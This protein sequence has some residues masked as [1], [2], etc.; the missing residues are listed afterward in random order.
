MPTTQKDH[1]LR[2]TAHCS[3]SDQ[4]RAATELRSA[5]RAIAD[6]EEGAA[7]R[8]AEAPLKELGSESHVLT[9]QETVTL[10]M[11]VDRA[12][13]AVRR[14]GAYDI[15]R[16]REV[17]QLAGKCLTAAVRAHRREL[18]TRR[19]SSGASASGATP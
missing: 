2:R 7:A 12:R 15:E 17:S 9:A 3:R 10:L 13:R 8:A 1:D 14:S 16:W 11:S 4:Q 18:A 6:N 5:L 19:R